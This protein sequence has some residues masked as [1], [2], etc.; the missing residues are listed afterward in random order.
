MTPKGLVATS[1]DYEVSDDEELNNNRVEELDEPPEE[2][3]IVVN[4]S[5][6]LPLNIQVPKI[7]LHSLILDFST[8]SFIDMS[9]MKVLKA[10]S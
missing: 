4:W 6:D 8:V 5:E 9:G 3:P 1:N 7:E 2:L 10:V